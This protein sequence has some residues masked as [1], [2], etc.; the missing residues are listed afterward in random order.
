[1]FYQRLGE[2]LV[3]H[4]WAVLVVLLILTVAS[5]LM[6]PRLKFD[7]RMEA[8]IDFSEEEKEFAQDFHER[9][10][11]QDNVL[12]VLFVGEPGDIYTP[13]GL[14]ALYNMTEDIESYEGVKGTYS[15]TRVPGRT[16]AGGL[17]A[18]F[19]G[20]RPP[21][22]VEEVPVTEVDI[23]EIK[24]QVEQSRII[25]RNLVSPDGS[26]A[27]VIVELEKEYQ[28]PKKL[29]PVLSKMEREIPERVHDYDPD[30]EV[31]FG[32]LPY[33]RMSTIRA[34][35]RE[36]MIMWPVVGLA[37][38]ILIFLV[39]RRVLESAMPLIAVGLA[40]L[41][42]VGLAAA[43]GM[44]ANMIN[45][46]LPTMILVVGVCNA[47]HVMSRILEERRAGKP[48]LEAIKG[49][50]SGIGL[51]SLLTTATTAIG[52][53]AL[54]VAHSD[55][56]QE[57]GILMAIGVMLTYIAIIVVLPVFATFVKL[58]IDSKE[59]RLRGQK[60]GDFIDA[61]ATAIMRYPWA[62][63]V[64]AFA[65]LGGCIWIGTK[66]PVDSR[67]IEVFREGHPVV[68]T[69]EII[70][71][72]LGG[73]LPLEVDIR[74]EPGT[75]QKA[76]P[77]QRVARFEREVA[78]LD[79][80]LTAM[81][82]VDLL[83]ETGMSERGGPPS[84][85]AVTSGLRVLERF[86]P[87]ALR[88]F[89]TE[90]YSNIRLS[91]RLPDS[92]IVSNL[93]TIHQIEALAEEHLKR[94]PPAET[95]T[96]SGETVAGNPGATP[97]EIDYRVTGSAYLS[98][99]G[100]D[101]FVRDLGLSLAT[102]TVII[103]F[104]LITVFRSL[105]VGLLALLPNL[106]PLGITLA[107]VPLFG[108]EL[109]TT[110]VVVFCIGIGLAVDNCIHLIARFRQESVAGYDVDEAIHRTLHT[111]G[112]A[113][114]TSNLL[115]IG[116]FS[117]LFAS[118]FDPILRVGQLTITTIGAGLLTSLIVLPAELKLFGKKMQETAR[119]RAEEGAFMSFD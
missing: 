88:S 39:F 1:M 44:A 108:Y 52:F 93:E 102:A 40:T 26:V 97:V 53:G 38:F 81:S 29:D 83:Q 117:V 19:L 21:P 15:L 92:G 73:I 86:Q 96:E 57:F 54:V 32:G 45:N 87:Q 59:Q 16:V 17:S 12:L 7:F 2:W 76:A 116:G 67:V 5:A 111:A 41:W 50:V 49:A 70:E 90:D 3:A 112:L 79:G 33:V 22:L 27:V 94:G 71:E 14:A 113:I 118:D 69:N 62:V 104:V 77:L 46:T 95:E 60:V 25:E 91:V 37:Y 80:V 107:V 105:R 6:V 9:F 110:T 24:E 89:A 72:K 99:V 28:A 13:E 23:A 66:I 8:M 115:L 4:R 30:L 82:L 20:G 63:L 47:I 114:I 78:E 61:G 85:A 109:N 100:L 106:L 101:T 64:A 35:K 31:R 84:D 65:V 10:D 42:T 75:F 55:L 11:T 34:L 103:F 58:D 74:A 68:E 36:Q 51:A 98:A 119:R 43:L 56:L 18:L 48:P